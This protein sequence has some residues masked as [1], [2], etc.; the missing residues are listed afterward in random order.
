MTGSVSTTS[1]DKHLWR[2]T[3]RLPRGMDFVSEWDVMT[4][5]VAV[6][7]VTEFD[8]V[9][10]PRWIEMEAPA[11]GGWKKGKAQRELA[12]RTTSD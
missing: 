7:V 9:P 1:A 3:L 12:S 10:R 2:A 5:N 8:Y 4:E 11:E 6:D